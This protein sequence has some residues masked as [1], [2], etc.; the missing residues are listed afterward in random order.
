[1]RLVI[2]SNRVMAA[3]LK[4]SL[5]REI[6]LDSRFEF[7]SPDY[8]LTELRKHKNYPLGKAKMNTK[9]FAVPRR[10]NLTFPG[11]DMDRG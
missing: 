4:N 11:W 6:L 10:W 9:Q 8:L 7:Y 3:L 2:D 1:M 5:T